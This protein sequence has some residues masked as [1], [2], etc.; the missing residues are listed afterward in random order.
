MV[1]AEEEKGSATILNVDKMSIDDYYSAML[2]TMQKENKNHWII[3]VSNQGL[4]PAQLE[5]FELYFL[6]DDN[7]CLKLKDGTR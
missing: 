2:D 4:N 7:K 1:V 5:T 3:L 6:L